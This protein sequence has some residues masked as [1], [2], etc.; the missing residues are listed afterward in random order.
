MSRHDQPGP[1]LILSPESVEQFNEAMREMA[2]I[3]GKWC[4]EFTRVWNN[5]IDQQVGLADFL[6]VDW[7]PDNFPETR[8]NDAGEIVA[9]T[10]K[11]DGSRMVATFKGNGHVDWV[12]N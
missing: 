10:T 9:T 6:S 2:R 1:R 12:V 7:D 11:A 8:L 3:V 4:D 5:A